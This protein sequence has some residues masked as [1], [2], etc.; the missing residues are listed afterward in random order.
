MVEMHLVST[1]VFQLLFTHLVNFHQI[2]G[3]KLIVDFP[4]QRLEFSI[5]VFLICVVSLEQISRFL[6]NL[7]VSL[8]KS[9]KAGYIFSRA[10][11]LACYFFLQLGFSTNSHRYITGTRKSG[12]YFSDLHL[13]YKTPETFKYDI[14][15]MT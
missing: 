11:D 8:G 13:I 1:L 5:T 3:T 14:S 15:S 6:P 7:P 4:H 10:Q 2:I 9:Q 12:F